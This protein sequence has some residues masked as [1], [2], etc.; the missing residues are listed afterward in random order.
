MSGI[1]DAL[2]HLAG[3]Q[4]VA[5]VLAVALLLGLRHATD[6]D[7]LAAV[8]TLI[9]AGPDDGIRRA[10]RLGLAW[11]LGHATTLLLFGLPIVLFGSYL[12]AWVQQGAEG[13]VGL[14]IVVL[15]ARLL[16]RWR[17]GRFHAHV[18]RHGEIEHRHLHPH[19]Q[20]E[21]HEHEHDRPAAQRLGRSCGQ[22]YGIGLVHGIGGSAGVG[23]LLLAG[24]PDHG[25]AIAALLLFA[26]AAAGSMAALSCGFG[27]A[28]TRGPVMRHVF[29][30]AP[31]LGLAALAFGT[32]YLLGALSAVPYPL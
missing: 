32:W 19:D 6:P 9:A 21:A 2:A 3:G 30:L 28:L 26:L 11:G 5:V 24:I 25:Q 10:G 15:A 8:S 12:P 1:D 23:V 14:V 13:L 17:R 27:Y 20:G 18:H 4:T 7:H 16:V 31:A 22:A 29:A